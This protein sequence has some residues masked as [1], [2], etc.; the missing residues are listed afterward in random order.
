MN[1]TGEKYSHRREI[2]YYESSA[3]SDD[4]D[5]GTVDGRSGLSKSKRRSRQRQE[6][7]LGELTKNFIKYIKK[8][9]GKEININDVVKELKV[10][11]RRIYDITNVLEGNDIIFTNFILLGI[12]YIKKLAKNKIQWIKDDLNSSFH[13]QESDEYNCESEIEYGE[14]EHL[15]NEF[16]ELMEEDKNLD[17]YIEHVKSQFEKLTED[18]SFK[19]YGYVTFED[20]KNLTIGDDINLIAI[21]APA[22]TS[23]EIPDP[24]HIHNIYLE[25]LEVICFL[26]IEYAKWKRHLR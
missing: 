15:E 19:E 3:T 22:G 8:Q 26:N 17:Q 9:G 16:N 2:K 11:K 5:D 6:N 25:T 12:G 24:D 13:S 10:K 7:S 4:G 1:Q 18:A 20:I 14:K 21:K 23:L